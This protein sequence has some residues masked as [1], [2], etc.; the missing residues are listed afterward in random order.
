MVDP[1]VGRR[2]KTLSTG[3]TPDICPRARFGTVAI[4]STQLDS[5]PTIHTRMLRPSVFFAAVLLLMSIPDTV[6]AQNQTSENSALS[7]EQ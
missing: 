1:E 6:N 2:I 5:E 3:E 4:P 7:P